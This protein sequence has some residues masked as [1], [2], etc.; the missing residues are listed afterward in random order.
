MRLTER[1]AG[2]G[3]AAPN[4]VLAFALVAVV[5][6]AALSAT[7]GVDSS[8]LTMVSAD[9]PHQA[10]QM[11]HIERFGPEDTLVFVVRGGDAPSRRLVATRLAQVI[12]DDPSLDALAL[13]RVT[14]EAMAEV[15]LLGPPS[16]P[17]DGIDDRGYLGSEALEQQYVLVFPGLDTIWQTSD[18]EPLVTRLRTLRD[19]ALDDLPVGYIVDPT[20]TPSAE[21]GGDE[22]G[23]P[24]VRAPVTAD[25]TGAP[26]LEVDEATAIS[27]GVVV[28]SVA[29]VTAILLVLAFG[30]RRGR[31]VA[32]TLVPVAI[33]VVATM[34]V[35]RVL[36]GELNMVTSSCSSI[37]LG[38]GIDFGVVLLDR[39]EEERE[40]GHSLADAIRRT[41]RHTGAALG[42]AATTSALAF[43][44]TATTEFTAYARLGV[45]VALGLA[46]MMVATLV[47][48]PALLIRF[49]GARSSLARR[50]PRGL[51]LGAAWPRATIAIAAVAFVASVVA[52]PNASFN[53]RFWDFLPTSSESA[54]GLHAIETDPIATPLR[55]TVGVDG[56]EEARALAETLRALPEVRAV[57]TGTDALPPLDLDAIEAR[58]VEAP[59]P[60][61]DPMVVRSWDTAS[62]VVARGRYAPT[63][64]PPVLAAQ[65]VSNDG[66]ALA[67]HVIPAGDVWDPVVAARFADAVTAVA[68]QATGLP[69]HIE[70]HLRWIRDGFLRAAVLAALVV[71]LAAW[72]AFR[73]VRDAAL[74]LVPPAFAFVGMIGAM[75][76][77]GLRFDPANVVA[78]PLIL[79]LSID[80]GL[81]IVHRARESA[82]NHGVARVED[83]LDGT[84]RAVGL[85]LVTTACGFAGLM[86][87]DYGA[88]QSLGGVM[89]LGLGMAAVGA[90]IVVPAIL[91]ATGRLTVRPRP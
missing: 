39:V 75:I 88:M 65:F 68:P 28:T 57:A 31:I 60:D 71:L 64:L 43:L 56:V 11:R 13:A 42:L 26:A 54:R 72:F 1:L 63:D 66:E 27:R 49:D 36:Y 34:A 18:I 55:A 69:M 48:M 77:L 30:F 41:W 38:L 7:L 82:A 46:L 80:A 44:T 9:H 10:A 70:T 35:A 12:S 91:K 58:L 8:R 45:L 89:V 78:L 83:V 86:L 21:P 87:A 84:G 5:V 20:Y 73:S 67:L 52:I 32:L 17:P 81:H 59:G 25:L 51:H 79:G 47:V 23:L 3:L 2:P 90:L 15:L 6:C 53:P 61:A 22:G 37:L 85:A 24:V 33:G 4:R 16:R 50:V 19:E 74:A 40:A 14:P 62:A 76:G 29:T